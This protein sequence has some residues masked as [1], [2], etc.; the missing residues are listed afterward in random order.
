MNQKT[1]A[2]A[3]GTMH[4]KTSAMGEY[5]L[6]TTTAI[7]GFAFRLFSIANVVLNLSCIVLL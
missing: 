6:G 5:R 7:V 4:Y 2:N 1:V 3:T